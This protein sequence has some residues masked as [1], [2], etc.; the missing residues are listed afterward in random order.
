MPLQ[1]DFL[2]FSA[3]SGANVLS[4][5]AYAA[6]SAT[7]TGFVT[8]TA[9]SAAANKTLRQASLMA[10]MIAHFIVDKAIQPVID[11]GT[12][13]TIEANFIAAILAVAETMDI[14]IPDVD[15]LVAAL[16]GKLDTTANAVSASKLATARNIAMSGVVGGAFNFDGSTNVSFTTY[17]GSSPNLPGIP[18]AATATAGTNN[19][20]L[21][22]TAFV[23]AAIAAALASYLPKNN[24]T[25]TGTMTGPL[26]NKA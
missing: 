14:T 24:P 16:A 9:S 15:G 18:T 21:A 25:F 20:Q 2:T 23:Q 13:A 19:T 8:G 12:T 4:Q 22:T 26:Y 11:D 1:N 10:A 5:A 6:A 7:A 17:F 3:A